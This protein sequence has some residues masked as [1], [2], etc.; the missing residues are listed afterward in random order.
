MTRIAPIV[1][2]AG[3]LFG[4]SDSQTPSPAPSAASGLRIGMKDEAAISLLRPTSLDWGR[5]Y[6]GGTG[7]SRLFFQ[8]STTQQVWLEVS[9]PP[10][11]TVTTISTPEP[12]TKWTRQDGD[13]I[14]VE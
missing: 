12:K 5:V 11:F 6:W 7:R 3:L 14:T 8:V 4:C 10:D 2:I 9:G 13:S 1:L